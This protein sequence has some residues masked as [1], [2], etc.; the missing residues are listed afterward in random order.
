MVL[1]SSGVVLGSVGSG[2]TLVVSL[3]VVACGVVVDGSSV[4]LVVCSDVFID[5]RV[6]VDGFVITVVGVVLCVVL[7]VLI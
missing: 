5:V 4:L 2:V 7:E 3:L 1:V 6:E